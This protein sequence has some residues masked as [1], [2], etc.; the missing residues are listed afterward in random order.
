M[1]N[2]YFNFQRQ[3][4]K[5]LIDILSSLLKQ[6]LQLRNSIYHE[7]RRTRSPAYEILKELHPVIRSYSKVLIVINA[8]DESPL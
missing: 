5:K 2:V 3:D 1:A 6:L 8:L 4:E 7:N